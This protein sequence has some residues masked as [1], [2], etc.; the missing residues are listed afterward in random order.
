LSHWILILAMGAGVGILL[1]F[2]GI[3]SGSVLT[4]LLILFGGLPPATAVGTSL[5]FASLTKVAGSW[6]FYRRGMVHMSIFRR[7]LVGALPGLLLGTGLLLRLRGSSPRLENVFL[8]RAIG[9]TLICVSLLMTA[10]FLQLGAASNLVER[11]TQ[12]GRRHDRPLVLLTGFAVGLAVTLTS[13]GAG[14]A[15]IPALYLV[16]RLDA[17]TLVGTSIFLGTVLSAAGALLHAGT[18]DV[19]LRVVGVLLLGSLPAIWLASHVHG[20]L[21]RQI[22]EG[23]LALTML[24]LAIR[25]FFL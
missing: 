17:G 21:P 25:F 2:T 18:G 1:G 16:Y 23:I 10:R 13:I 7:L 20:R 6:R 5:V 9:A 19:D 24:A 4:P 8:L 14:A 15:L 3:G 22:T 11:V 12:L